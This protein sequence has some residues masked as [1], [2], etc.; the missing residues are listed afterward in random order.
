MEKFQETRFEPGDIALITLAGEGPVIG[1][2]SGDR[3]GWL[4]VDKKKR[5]PYLAGEVS[6]AHGRGLNPTRILPIPVDHE[7]VIGM[8]DDA[9][10][11][12]VADDVW[13]T[14]RPGQRRAWLKTAINELATPR[15]A[16]PTTWAV[17]EASC[18]HSENRREWVRHADGNWYSVQSHTNGNPDDWASLIRPTL[19]RAGVGQ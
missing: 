4:W 18:V 17:V 10:E 15:I 7:G 2:L 11:R 8:L 14:A 5:N 12:A 3:E 16:E 1:M 13:G 6:K 19:V 9:I